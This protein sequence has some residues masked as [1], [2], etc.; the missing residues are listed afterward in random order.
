LYA[1][2][3]ILYISAVNKKKSPDSERMS[4]IYPCPVYKYPRR[5][6]RYI[7]SNFKVTLSCEGSGPHKWRLRGVAILCSTDV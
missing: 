6:D 3:P 4:T 7:L 1:K 2:L 5:T